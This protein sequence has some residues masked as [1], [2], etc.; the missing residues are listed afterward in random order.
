MTLTIQPFTKPV[1][2]KIL[3]PGSKSL[4]NRL[5]PLAVLSEKSVIITGS[6]E[7]EDAEIMRDALVKMGAHITEIKTESGISDWKVETASFFTNTDN[8]ELFCGNS[9]TSIRFL[10]ALCALRKGKTTLTGTHRMLVRPIGD[11]CDVL[12]NLGVNIEYN[13]N[14]NFPPHTIFPS[15]IFTQSCDRFSGMRKELKSVHLSG[16]LSSQFF[17]ALFHIAPKIGLEIIVDNELVSKPYIDM[18]IEVMKDFG[19]HIENVQNEY[20]IFK[21]SQ[22]KF[23][24]PKTGKFEVEGDASSATYPL[25][26]GLITGGNVEITNLPKKSLQ[27][28]AKFKELV[29]DKM[30][31]PENN[32]INPLIPL[33]NIDLEDIPDAALTAIVLCGYAD[34]YTKITG[35]STL[36]HKECDRLF[37]METNLRKMGI[38]V[39]TGTDYIE[40]WGDS[41]KIHG[42]EIEC[43]DD[44]RIAMSFAVLGT[45]VENVK[46]LDPECTKKTFPSFW[47][48]L[49]KWRI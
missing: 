32:T 47:E 13:K 12:Q 11:L 8:I 39:K 3:V 28:D 40:I 18:T 42:A 45:V 38:E 7:S 17:T 14:T 29:I 26:I 16:K 5:F 30:R 27:G 43:F 21:I 49:E 15:S 20:A 2:K 23:T 24:V 22:Q 44:H 36:R 41:K 35:L 10:T 6:L 46:I 48:D 31:N 25:A 4:T 37:A 34:G 19:V 1:C 33:G 9:G